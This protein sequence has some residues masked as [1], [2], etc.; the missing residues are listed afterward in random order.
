MKAVEVTEGASP[1]I[2]GMPHTGLHIPPTI[3]KRLN[4]RG[5]MMSDTDWHV[6]QLYAGLLTDATRVRATF[7]RYCI[8]ANRDPEGASLYP[9]QNTTG[10]VPE[11]DF[12]GQPIWNGG[13]KPGPVETRERIFLYHKPYH[14]ALAS[15]IA[16]IKAIYGVA[17]LFDCH[18]IRSEIPFLF[19]GKLADFN[20]GTNDG[21]TCHPEMEK[22]VAEI[23]R[24]ADG[25]TT[26]LNGR[27]KGG[28]TTRHYGRPETGVHTIQ[29]E[30]AQS[31][32]LESEDTPFHYSE[33]KAANLRP[34]LSDILHRLE[35]LAL[36][37]VLDRAVGS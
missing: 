16:R 34:H 22:A 19:E 11:T 24:N 37:G 35:Q 15:Q 25:Y 21:T 12:D 10:L 26:T 30:I 28:W 18:S 6:E 32:Y 9:G 29:L 14:E 2:L 3:M 27:F 36:D 1:V 4:L 20:I 13:E 33:L 5:H 17:I 23:C 8:D 31:A 7:H